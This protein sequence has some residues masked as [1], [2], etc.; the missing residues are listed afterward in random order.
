[1]NYRGVNSCITTHAKKSIVESEVAE[2]KVRKLRTSKKTVD[3]SVNA[4]SSVVEETEKKKRGRKSRVVAEDQEVSS[5][6]IIDC[7]KSVI[8]IQRSANFL[9]EDVQYCSSLSLFP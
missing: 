4:D 2:P 6:T 3:E 7:I 9:E 8:Y 1:M 5:V